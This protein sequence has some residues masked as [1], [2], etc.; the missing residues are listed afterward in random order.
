MYAMILVAIARCV[1]VKRVL[2]VNAKRERQKRQKAKQKSKWVTV[3]YFVI[4]KMTDVLPPPPLRMIISGPSGSGKG[5]LA[6]EILLK[7]HRGKY[8]KIYYFSA[9]ALVDDNLNPLQKYCEE[10]LGQDSKKDPCL[11]DH[12]DEAV[13]DKILERQTAIVDYMKRKKIKKKTKKSKKSKEL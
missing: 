10:H 11:Y 9:S 1:E 12:W 4:D 5:I 6:S 7:H 3:V 2:I 8:E 13:L